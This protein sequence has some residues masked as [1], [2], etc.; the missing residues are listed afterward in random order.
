MNFPLL[1][2]T[3]KIHIHF[4]SHNIVKITHRLMIVELNVWIC[5]ILKSLKNLLGKVR[6]IFNEQ[7]KRKK[8][9]QSCANNIDA[10]Q[11]EFTTYAFDREASLAGDYT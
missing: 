1:I 9:R 3:N 4:L 6:I 7:S 8:R 2:H 10:L 5:S 11:A